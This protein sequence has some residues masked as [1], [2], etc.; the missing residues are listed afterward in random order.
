MGKLLVCEALEDSWKAF[1][2]PVNPFQGPSN[3]AHHVFLTYKRSG[4]SRGLT[5]LPGP[6]KALD[7]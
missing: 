4:P 6:L 5:D 1:E 7:L 2:S 3:G